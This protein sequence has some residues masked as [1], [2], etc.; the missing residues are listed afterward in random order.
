M[1][2]YGPRGDA[3]CH[4]TLADLEASLAALPPAPREEGRLERI[5]RRHA[6]GVREELEQ[7]RLSVE[8]GLPG[9]AWSR[10]PPRDP[11]AQLAVMRSDVAALIAGG[12]PLTVFGDNLFVDLELSA[13]NLP[14]GTRLAVGEAIVSV[15]PMPHDGCAKFSQRFGPDALRLVQA[16]ATRTRNLRGIYWKVVEPGLA[17]SGDPVRVLS[18][19]ASARTRGSA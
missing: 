11:E 13:D 2:S 12:Q 6:D 4:R 10:R 5:V 3:H 7:A 19:P 15:T 18:R 9:D 14:E 16:R 1:E 17:R 8:E